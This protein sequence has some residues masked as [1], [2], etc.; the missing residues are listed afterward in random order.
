MGVDI[1]LK[2]TIDVDREAA[3]AAAALLGTGTLKETVNAALRDVVAS[4]GRRELSRQIRAGELPVPTVEELARL[5]APR[6]PLGALD[7]LVEGLPRAGRTR[8]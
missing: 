3:D 7:H 1:H 5:R 2:T 8:R 6:I 4:A